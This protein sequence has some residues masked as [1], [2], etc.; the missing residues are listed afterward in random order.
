M[1]SFEALN[2]PVF[3]IKLKHQ[4]EK[5]WVFDSIRKKW[6][7]L[8]PEEWVRQHLINYLIN[9]KEFPPSLISLESGLKYHVL[10]K[11][12]DVL[13]YS[14]EG[15]PVMIVECKAPSVAI[16]QKVLEQISVYNTSVK[17]KYLCVT[18]GLKHF[19]W[20]V[21]DHQFEFQK[22]IPGWNEIKF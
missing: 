16:S 5:S 19:C 4:P 18:N 22:A 9:Y 8:T 15:A 3:D 17:A 21:T 1:K 12:S 11:R 20:T 7:V 6:L 2:F 13:V 14:P 10:S